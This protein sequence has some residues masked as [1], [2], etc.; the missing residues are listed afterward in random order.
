MLY[1]TMKGEFQLTIVFMELI[2]EK[3]SWDTHVLPFEAKQ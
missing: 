3:K 2:R 1:V